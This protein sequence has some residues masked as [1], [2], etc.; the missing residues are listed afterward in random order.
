MT[1]IL[2]FGGNGLIGAHTVPLLVERGHEVVAFSRGAR[3]ADGVIGVEQGDIADKA[4]VTRAFAKWRPEAVLQLAATLQFHCEED[5]AGA[6][7]TNL[8]G[9]ANA[10]E[11]AAGHGTRRFIFASSIAAYGERRDLMREDDPPPAQVTL[12][13]EMKRLGERLGAQFAKLAGMEY[14]ALRYSG[15]FGPRDPSSGASGR[16]MSL[17]RHLLIETAGGRDAELD[18]VDGSETVHL[19]YVADA[20]EATVRALTNAG[21]A[22]ALYNI[23]GPAENHLSLKGFHAAVKRAAPMAGAAHFGPRPGAKGA[24]MRDDLGYAPRH[25]VEDGVKMALGIG[26]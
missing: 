23:G 24:R 4:A 22:H 10:F 19:T 9:A 6:V 1:R 7:A 12:Y 3:A 16:G 17:A 8:T 18:F 15:V 25:S 20:A 11:A 2:V 14:A 26:A 5:P 13:G 21:I